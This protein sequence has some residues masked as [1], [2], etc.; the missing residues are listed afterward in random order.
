M[1]EFQFWMMVKTYLIQSPYFLALIAGIGG[2]LYYWKKKPKPPLFFVAG[3]VGL[4]IVLFTTTFLDFFLPYIMFKLDFK[5]D[6][7][8]TMMGFLHFFESVALAIAWIP[9]VLMGLGWSKKEK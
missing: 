8:K 5:Y 6:T 4:F 2:G 1:N 3:S 9:I 7:M